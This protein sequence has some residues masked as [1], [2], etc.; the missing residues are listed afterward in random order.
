MLL[1]DYFDFDKLDTRLGVAERIR[2]KGHRIAI[3]NVIELFN[4]GIGPDVI[5]R[6]YYPSLTLEEVYAT[7]TYYLHNKQEV[8]AYL[9]RGK[10]LEEAFHEQYVQKG[11]FFLKDQGSELPAGHE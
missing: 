9:L 8:D 5:Q 1:E 3:E 6:D 10:Q 2:V 4:Q 7:I 11:P